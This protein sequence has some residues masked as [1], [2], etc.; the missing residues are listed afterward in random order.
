[1]ETLFSPFQ[2][3]K[4]GGLGI[5]LMI[6]RSIVEAHAGTIE[7]H[8]NGGRGIAFTITLPAGAGST[9]FWGDGGAHQ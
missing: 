9:V 1:M 2:T 3:T 6:A 8:A 5:G 7:A 4:T